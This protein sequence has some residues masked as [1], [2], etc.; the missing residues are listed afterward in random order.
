[1]RYKLNYNQQN[2]KSDIAIIIYVIVING[3]ALKLSVNPN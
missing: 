2:F 3:S 1:M